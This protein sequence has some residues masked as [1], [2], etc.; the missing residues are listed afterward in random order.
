MALLGLLLVPTWLMF[1]IT[2][3]QG[4]DAYSSPLGPTAVATESVDLLEPGDG[5]L[6]EEH[7]REISYHLQKYEQT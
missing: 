4:E 3:A 7:F 1:V 5:R 2:G 6:K